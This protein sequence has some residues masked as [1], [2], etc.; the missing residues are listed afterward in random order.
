MKILAWLGKKTIR[1]GLSTLILCT[2]LTIL[3]VNYTNRT[4]ENI[5]SN[6]LRLHIVAN[7]DSEED[8]AIKLKVR[9][10]VIKQV[11]DM[12]ISAENAAD[13]TEDISEKIDVLTNKINDY[14]TSEGYSQ[15]AEINLGESIFPAKN[16]GDIVLPAGTYNA[17]KVTLGEGQGK[18]WW[19]VM[20][21]PLCCTNSGTLSISE[22]GKTALK[23]TL[24]DEAYKTIIGDVENN[25]TLVAD[26]GLVDED[27]EV[28]VR[29]KIVEIFKEGGDKISGL[30]GKCKKLFA[31]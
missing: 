28:N 14:L 6:I 8:Q 15:K 1:I 12:N 26:D 3:G 20:F 2:L 11:S 23:E 13:Y 27:V 22:E 19:C 9:D 29:F 5:K 4:F 17:I 30:W 24:S 21:P 16:Y 18:N 25:V 31:R 10:M 7:S